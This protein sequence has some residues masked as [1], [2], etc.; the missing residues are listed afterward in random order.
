MNHKIMKSIAGFAVLLM[1][2]SVIPSSALAA[3]TDTQDDG[4]N[5][6]GWFKHRIGGLLMHEN[7]HADRQ[8]MERSAN[9][10]RHQLTD[11]EKTN[12]MKT[13]MLDMIDRQVERLDSIISEETD[14]DKI[15]T[16]E[17]W[18]NQLEEIKTSI[19]G[20]DVTTEEL[21]EA[22]DEMHEIM[23]EMMSSGICEPMDKSI[24]KAVGKPMG[25]HFCSTE[26]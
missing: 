8:N 15:A 5:A 9:M 25:H 19:N 4:E 22:G 7:R 3:E 1:V 21:Q 20:E 14:V 23:Q 2:F 13:K 26:E 12:F 11:E 6:V 10:E 17:D 16:I 24:G 18:I